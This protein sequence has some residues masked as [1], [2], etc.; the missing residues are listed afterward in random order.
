MKLSL[1]HLL[2][3]LYLFPILIRSG[4]SEDPVES[5]TIGVHRAIYNKWDDALVISGQASTA[6]VIV[7]PSIGGRIVHYGP[8]KENIIYEVPGSEGKTLAKNKGGF[9]AG[10]YQLDIGPEIRVPKHVALWMGQYTS[11]CPKAYTVTV[12]SEDNA[13]T[14]IRLEKEIMLDPISKKSNVSILQR[15]KNISDK[16]TSFCLWDR[17]LCNG[18]GFVFFPLNRKSRMVAG[19]GIRE[20]NDGKESYNS[21]TPNSPNVKILEGV[22][23]ATTGG[24]EGKVGADSD[25]G[26]MAYARGTQL[27]IKTFPYVADGNY[28]DYGNSVEFYWSDKVGEVEPLS[29]EIKLKPGEEFIFQE[30]WMLIKLDAEVDSFEK[31]RALVDLVQAWVNELQNKK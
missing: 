13:A 27:Y 16:E 24:K 31:A 5:P 28:T 12:A 11:Q 22:L 14:G 4:L 21:T 26:W 2:I 6:S 1:L 20:K 18:G 30:R 15:M 3:V 23:V 10:G 9:W 7:I 29:P 19:W 17:T 8:E 25:A